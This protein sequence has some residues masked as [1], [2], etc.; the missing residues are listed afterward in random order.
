MNNRQIMNAVNSKLVIS[1]VHSWIYF[2]SHKML[3]WLVGGFILLKV[4]FIVWV[5]G[6]YACLFILPAKLLQEKNLLSH[7]FIRRFVYYCNGKQEGDT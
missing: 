4:K 6:S 5:L 3:Q 2:M 1:A 7:D